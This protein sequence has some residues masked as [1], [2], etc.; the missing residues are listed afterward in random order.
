MKPTAKQIAQIKPD[1]KDGDPDCCR[2]VLGPP[3]LASPKGCDF[4][5]VSSV[6]RE[7][8][9][10]TC[11]FPGCDGKTNRCQPAIKHLMVRK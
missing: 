5:H 9:V 8:T 10:E 7:P 3:P 2:L 11:Q 4:Y 6:R 1:W